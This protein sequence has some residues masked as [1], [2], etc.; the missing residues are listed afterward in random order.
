[1]ITTDAETARLHRK[2]ETHWVMRV[3]EQLEFRI[4][5]DPD[6]PPPMWALRD[7]LLCHGFHPYPSDLRA[8][9]LA[10]ET[11][12]IRVVRDPE[13]LPRTERP[14]TVAHRSSHPSL[15]RNRSVRTLRSRRW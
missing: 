9:E 15:S 4:E 6:V 10:P 14:A 12:R 8:W 7:T 3:G 13:L 2:S 11:T 5:H 1:M